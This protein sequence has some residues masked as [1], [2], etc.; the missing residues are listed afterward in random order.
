MACV[1]NLKHRTF[2]LTLYSTGMRLNEAAHLRI[3]DI[4]SH[5]M[6][7]RIAAGKGSK[8][9]RVPLSPRLLTELREY[10]KQYRPTAYL[11]PGKTLDVPFASTTIH[12]GTGP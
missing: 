9:R 5:R 2:L 7:I 10:W 11:F 1:S 4:D 3:A 12:K 6:Q 8:E